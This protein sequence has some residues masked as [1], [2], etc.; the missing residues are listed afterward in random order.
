MIGMLH[1][2]CVY[3]RVPLSQ[4]PLFAKK[5]DIPGISDAGRVNEFLYRGTQPNEEGVEQLKKLGIHTIVDLRG[6][7]PGTI[8]KEREQAE[9]LGMRF[10]SIAGNGWSPPADEQVAQFLSLFRESPKRKIFVHCWLGGDRTGVF[11][12]IYRITFDGWQPE[13]ALEEMDAFHFKGFWHPAMKN[14]IRHF[15][16]RLAQSPVLARF[17]RAPYSVAA[18]SAQD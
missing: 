14:Y 13:Q 6:E 5:I 2:G 3:R 12:A 7:K 4:T 15:P 1:T 16:E 18:G 17:R 8:E 9:A 11:I 10:L